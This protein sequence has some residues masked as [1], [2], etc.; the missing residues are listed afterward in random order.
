MA[1]QHKPVLHIAVAYV[2]KKA[3][4][5]PL[6]SRPPDLLFGCAALLTIPLCALESLLEIFFTNLNRGYGL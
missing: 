3:S 2:A 1:P 6:A 5:S 4:Y